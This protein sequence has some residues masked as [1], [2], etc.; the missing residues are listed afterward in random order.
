MI[1]LRS[2]SVLPKMA[3]GLVMFK[4]KFIVWKIKH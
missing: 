2:M 4:N 3:S 1:F